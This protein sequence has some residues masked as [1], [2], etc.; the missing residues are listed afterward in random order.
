MLNSNAKNF[1]HL[2]C[3]NWTKYVDNEPID[4][5]GFKNLICVITEK[6]K[7]TG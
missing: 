6:S 1:L 3:F 5:I 4:D 7:F 2:D